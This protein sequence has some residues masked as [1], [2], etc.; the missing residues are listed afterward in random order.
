MRFVCVS[1]KIVLIFYLLFLTSMCV[2][3]WG[4]LCA[5]VTVYMHLYLPM[6]T[7]VSYIYIRAYDV[8]IT[9]LG[10][11]DRAINKWDTVS[12]HIHILFKLFINSLNKLFKTSTWKRM[13][14]CCESKYRILWKLVANMVQLF[15][16]RSIPGWQMLL[17]G[18][19]RILCN[20]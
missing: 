11:R 5:F 18:T 19:S 8:S 20:K 3:V 14:N 2:G 9:V 4:C 13:P 15:T 6:C 10:I 7:C 1:Y 17:S 16:W 12:T